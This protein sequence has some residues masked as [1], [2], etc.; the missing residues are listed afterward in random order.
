MSRYV[1]TSTEKIDVGGE[2]LV[3]KVKQLFHERDVRRISVSDSDGKTVLEMPV[4]V[5]VIG[6]LVAPSVTAIGTL[7]ALA[8]DYS[9]EIERERAEREESVLTAASWSHDVERK[10]RSMDRYR[11]LLEQ[12][13]ERYNEGDLDGCMELYAEDAVQLMPDGVFEG[14]DAIRERLTRE[15]ALFLTSSGACS[16]T[17]SRAMRSLTSGPSPGR[18][19][20]RCCC[21]TAVNCRQRASAW[22]S[23][24][25]SSWK[26]VTARS[27]STISTTTTSR[28][29][30]SSVSSRS[31]SRP[32]RREEV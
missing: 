16:A 13:V 11:G 3:Q 28:W 26:C 30:S 21:Q 20:D 2:Q 7:G 5:G 29:P 22:R 14:R 23:E 9:I 27:S 1:T 12:Y 31:S 17:S 15:L 18:I 6:L 19:P 4:T 10:E 24:A 32:R 25:W 8:A